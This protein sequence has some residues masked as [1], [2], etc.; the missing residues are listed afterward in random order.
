MTKID[1]VTGILGAGK[2]TFLLRYG[3]YLLNK[4]E[5]IA[6]IVNDFGAVTVDMLLLKELKSD[7]CE[8]VTICGCGDPNAGRRRF[9]TQLINM[10]M[11]HLDRVIIEPSGLFDIDEFFDTLYESPL[12]RWYE[13][14][15][16]LTLIDAEM[17]AELGDQMEYLLA[18]EAACAGK[19]VVSKLEH[20]PVELWTER[21]GQLLEHVNRA[22]GVIRCDR[23]F[24]ESDLLQKPLETL[25]DDDFT[26]LEAAGYRKAPYV[27]LFNMQSIRSSIH[28]F[29]HLRFPDEEIERLIRQIM[30]DDACGKIYRIKGSLPSSDGGW[31]KINA[32]PE[33]IEMQPV[34]DGQS[35]LIVIGDELSLEQIDAHLRE[36]NQDPE[37]VSV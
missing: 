29:M 27:K 24:S 34:A 14:G 23:R 28:Y 2:T 30:G 12:D 26:Y 15:S 1:L 22:L 13:I 32:T 17:E 31:F 18:S 6:I 19:L 7:R 36:K 20:L 3:R 11:Q 9:K 37:Y 8:I 5:R 10:G 16:V 21:T 4:G 35:V 25:N 33:R